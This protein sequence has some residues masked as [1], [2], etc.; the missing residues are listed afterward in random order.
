[1]HEWKKSIVIVMAVCALAALALIQP[2]IV[3]DEASS[4]ETGQ[5]TRA[6]EDS[7]PVLDGAKVFGWYCGSCHSE[8]YPRERTDAE[9]EVIVTHMR[10]RSNLTGEQADAV[11]HYLKENNE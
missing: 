9:W 3:A 5:N 8:R 1:M 7:K 6:A 11:L 2:P 4:G 10:V